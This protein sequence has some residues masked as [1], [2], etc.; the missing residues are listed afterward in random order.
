MED[1]R[2]WLDSCGILYP[3]SL[4]VSRFLSYVSSSWL[5]SIMFLRIK[6]GEQNTI[7]VNRGRAPAITSRPHHGVEYDDRQTDRLVKL[8]SLRNPYDSSCLSAESQE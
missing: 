5:C 3:P 4:Y 7:R 8:D 1:G 2:G 6:S